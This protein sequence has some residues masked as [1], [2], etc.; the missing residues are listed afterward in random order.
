LR[1]GTS[2]ASRYGAVWL[3]VLL[4]LVAPGVYGSVSVNDHPC[5][6]LAVQSDKD[7][8]RIGE[9]VNVTVSYAPVLPGCV[10]FMIAHDYVITIQILNGSNSVEYSSN[11]TTTGALTIH[12][13]WTPLATG[14]FTINATSWFRLL[15]GDSMMKQMEASK[16][17]H[18]QAPPLTPIPTVGLA[19]ALVVIGGAALAVYLNQRR[20]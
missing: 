18:V 8:Y 9:S 16:L 17:I 3:L 20:K 1:Y 2:H 6:S 19:A 12:D 5:S 7:T 4:V 14:D 13:Q 15:G 11:H 10:E